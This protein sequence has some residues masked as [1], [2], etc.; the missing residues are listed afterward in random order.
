MTTD[1]PGLSPVDW[2]ADGTA[3]QFITGSVARP[4]PGKPRQ[5][6]YVDDTMRDEQGLIPTLVTEGAPGHRPR[7]N[8]DDP[9][10]TWHWGTDLET[11]EE[12]MDLVNAELFGIDRAAANQ[13]IASSM[14]A[15]RTEDDDQDDDTVWVRITCEVHFAGCHIADEYVAFDRAEW[16]EM[17]EDQRETVLA[18]MAT[19]ALSGYASSGASV[20]DPS[21]VPAGTARR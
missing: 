8:K 1:A 12:V 15:A 5:A 14:G 19:E 11:A 21:E 10:G 18:D 9:R 4:E 16:D 2:L 20:V 17:T 7:I 6:F 3:R 13:I